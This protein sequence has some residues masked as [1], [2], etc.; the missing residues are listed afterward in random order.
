MMQD[1]RLFLISASM[2]SSL[3]LAFPWH[4]IS[5]L[6]FLYTLP[7]YRLAYRFNARQQ[8]LL[9]L[10]NKEKSACRRPLEAVYSYNRIPYQTEEIIMLLPPSDTCPSV[11]FLIKCAAVFLIPLW[12]IL[13]SK[14]LTCMS[15]KFWTF[16]LLFL[17]LI[18]IIRYFRHCFW[19]CSFK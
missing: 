10:Q 4:L 16:I 19:A 15:Q 9:H 1:K 17:V 7:R 5:P 6:L 11:S 3:G 13:F 12:I 14:I 8:A 2:R 18:I